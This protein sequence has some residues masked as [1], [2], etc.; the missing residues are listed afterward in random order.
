MF[1]LNHSTTQWFR[2]PGPFSHGISVLSQTMSHPGPRAARAGQALIAVE[3][4]ETVGVFYS[5]SL[6]GPSTKQCVLGLD[7]F[8]LQCTKGVKNIELRASAFRMVRAFVRSVAGAT[9]REHAPISHL[10]S[11]THG[12]PTSDRR[13]PK[14]CVATCQK[15][16]WWGE[17]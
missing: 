12:L 9:T 6:G 8:N 3:E 7:G 4:D 13:V 11:I 16:L 17:P 2:S 5:V 15:M 1:L 10:W 14:P